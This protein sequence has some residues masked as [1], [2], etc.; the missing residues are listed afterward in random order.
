MPV[1]LIQLFAPAVAAPA[2]P[3]QPGR[4]SPA[5]VPST[6]TLAQ[7]TRPSMQFGVGVGCMP[8]PRGKRAC[9]VGV[10]EL[11]AASLMLKLQESA[12][13]GEHIYATT[14]QWIHTASHTGA[15]H[16]L[17]LPLNRPLHPSEAAGGSKMTTQISKKRKVCSAAPAE[18]RR[19]RPGSLELHAACMDPSRGQRPN[20]ALLLCTPSSSLTASSTPS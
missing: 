17:G 1:H 4:L 11:N 2:C 13:A 19:R 10:A 12:L 5:Q 8:P 3:G 18:W 20:T 14:V 7:L 15:T 9:P 16:G 6:Q